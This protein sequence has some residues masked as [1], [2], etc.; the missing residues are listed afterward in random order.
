MTQAGYDFLRWI[1]S[2]QPPPQRRK[3]N[4]CR[5]CGKVTK[6]VFCPPCAA[7]RFASKQAGQ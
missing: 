7:D 5:Q 1:G 3:P 2:R 6:H 4:R